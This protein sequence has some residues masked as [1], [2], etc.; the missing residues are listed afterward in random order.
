MA[1]KKDKYGTDLKMNIIISWIAILNL[2]TVYLHIKDYIFFHI[3]LQ[4]ATKGYMVKCIIVNF[5][6][7]ALRR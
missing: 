2:P 1:I 5:N 3:C 6:M 7:S 4:D